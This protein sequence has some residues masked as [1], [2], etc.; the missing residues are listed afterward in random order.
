[1]FFFIELVEF[2]GFDWGR[3]LTELV[4]IC[5]REYTVYGFPELKTSSC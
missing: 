2:R 3:L 4:C 1:M 5:V